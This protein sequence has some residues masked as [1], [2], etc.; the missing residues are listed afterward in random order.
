MEF[1]QDYLTRKCITP[2]F[3][4]I[5]LSACNMFRIEELLTQ[6]REILDVIVKLE[7]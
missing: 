4:Y 5:P 6:S 7:I 2:S 1:L 3:F